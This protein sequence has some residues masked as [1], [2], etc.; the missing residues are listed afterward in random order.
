MIIG[1]TIGGATTKCRLLFC[2]NAEALRL[3]DAV[4]QIRIFGLLYL[5]LFFVRF[6]PW[7]CACWRVGSLPVSVFSWRGRCWRRA[8]WGGRS[9]QRA[10]FLFVANRLEHCDA[11]YWLCRWVSSSISPRGPSWR[12]NVSQGGKHEKFLFM[13]VIKEKLVKVIQLYVIRVV[14]SSADLHVAEYTT[15]YFFIK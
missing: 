15:F 11:N 10:T 13:I 14:N 1:P 8:A 2:S 4:K 9:E 5:N 7:S 6:E 3:L 12:E